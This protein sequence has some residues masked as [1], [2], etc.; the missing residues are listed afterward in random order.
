MEKDFHI[1]SFD[2][3]FSIHHYYPMQI[4]REFDRRID[5][6]RQEIASLKQQL[7]TAETYLEA[8]LDMAKLLPKEGGKEPELR[9]GSDL[10]RARDFIKVHGRP[11]HVTDILKGLGKE[12]NK[13]NK[14]SLSGSLGGYARKGVI[15]TKPAPNTFGLIE[16]ENGGENKPEETFEQPDVFSAVPAAKFSPVPPRPK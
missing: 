10:A 9:A 13:P 1:F 6:K 5:K 2:I 3:S 4:Q 7:L 15:F 14:I 16:F 11:Q 8:M 12:V